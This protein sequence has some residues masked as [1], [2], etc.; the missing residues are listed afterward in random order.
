M[1]SIIL[2]FVTGLAGPITN[3]VGKLLDLKTAREQA[4]TD[5]QKAKIDQQIEDVHD[6]KAVLIA[7][8]GNRIV[9]VINGTLRGLGF[10][11]ALTFFA[12]ITVWDKVI[13]SFKGCAGDGTRDL[14]QCIT[15]RTDG[16]D[17]NMLWVLLGIFG[18]YYLTTRKT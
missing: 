1:L 3:V 14:L 4:Q 15:H 7:E 8:A 16:L 17:P 12:K 9:S 18:F 6:Q 2:G 10:L 11:T 5:V 13:G